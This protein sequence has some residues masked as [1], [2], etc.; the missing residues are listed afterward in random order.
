[1]PEAVILLIGPNDSIKFSNAPSCEAKMPVH[2]TNVIKIQ[3]A[4]A[5][6]ENALFWDW[7][8]FMGGPC[9]IRSWAAQDLAR[10]DNVHLSADGYKKSAQGLYRQLS[11]MLN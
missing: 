1:M 6:Q 11:Q 10:P 5:A 8:A 4:V 9:S 3:K 2:L 7:Q